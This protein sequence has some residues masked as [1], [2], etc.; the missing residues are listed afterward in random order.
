MHKL[1]SNRRC[2]R[3]G[4]G[5]LIALVLGFVAA[6]GVAESPDSSD[7]ARTEDGA[8]QR[9]SE[10]NDLFA[11]DNLVAWCIV[12]FDGKK[13]GPAERAEMCARLGLRKIAYD[14]RA[15]HVKS[16][17]QE[18]LEYKRNGLE[19]FAFW[20]VH[21]EAFRL[22]QKHDLHPQIWKML[23]QPQ[24]KTQAERVQAAVAEIL[25]LVE[26][27]RRL[28]FRLG[29]YNHGGWSGEP[30]NLVAVCRAL[31]KQTSADHVGIVYNLHHAHDHIEDFD[32]QLELMRPYLL[33]LNLNGMTSGGD[34]RG[35]K[36]VPLGSGE[37]DLELLRVI[38][39][40][41]YRGPIGV[42]GHTQDDVELRLR[43]NLDGLDWLRRRLDGQE[44]GPPPVP[45]TWAPAKRPKASG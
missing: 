10:P 6:A 4:T 38:R 13:R 29:L 3:I 44:A 1:L 28:G 2:R 20:G 37:H 22:F 8:A 40:S 34:R 16:F 35:Q 24:A 19:Y 15:E 25:P 5:L 7:E 41:G 27:T 23:P 43:D 45:R 12:P 9:S 18:I 33:C 17:E 42:I 14:W 11:R 30:Q 26:R 32:Q 39:R 36:I 31:R 21:D